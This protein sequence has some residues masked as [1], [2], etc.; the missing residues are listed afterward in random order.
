MR[1]MRFA[2]LVYFAV[3][4]G[5]PMPSGAIAQ[6]ST[7]TS[8]SSAVS[9]KTAPSDQ[10]ATAS[11]GDPSPASFLNAPSAEKVAVT[12]GGV[13]IRTGRP[14]YSKT[15]LSIG[16]GGGA[17]TLSRITPTKIP[18]HVSPFGNFAHNWDIVLAIRNSLPDQSTYQCDYIANVSFGGRSQTFEK[19]YLQDSAFRQKS[20]NDFT[21]L[22]TS[23]GSTYTY[24]A[25]DG[26]IAVFNA[27][28]TSCSGSVNTALATVSYVIE[29]DGTRF[30]FEYTGSSLAAVTSSRGYALLLE[31]GA[32]G[33]GSRITKACVLNLGSAAKPTSNVCPATALATAT[34][35]YAGIDAQVTLA[36]AIQPDGNA[37]SFT[38]ASVTPNVTYE[39]GFKK[40]GQSTAWKTNTMGYT[41]TSE[42]ETEPYVKSQ[43]FADGSGFAYGYDFT[44]STLDPSGNSN[45]Y[46]TIAGGAYTNALGQTIEV[47]YDFP[48]TPAS[49]NPR[50]S[51]VGTAP[52]GMF[53][54]T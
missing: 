48:I 12:P 26:T 42:G 10:P 46:D 32:A 38:Y 51:T 50:V 5:C 27:I 40:P 31:Y 24:Q 49:Y 8:S 14:A 23:N 28:S 52:G 4:L 15:D 19:L 37:E 36:S 41:L 20:Q 39:M 35:T 13:D 18:G 1:V 22:T 21:R 17:I 53:M 30:D 44:P 9:P 29:P 11:F 45:S 7:P 16:S 6:T 33:G 25:T 43:S 3:S 47:R 2:G 54:S 34:Y